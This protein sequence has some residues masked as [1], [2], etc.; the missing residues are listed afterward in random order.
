MR[1]HHVI[2][3]AAIALSATAASLAGLSAAPASAASARAVVTG[4][5]LHDGKPVKGAQITLYAWPAQSVLAKEAVGQEVPL[6][7]VGTA[8]S[9]GSGKFSVPA[10]PGSLAAV[11]DTANASGIVNLQVQAVYDGHGT[12]FYFPRRVVSTA[13]GMALARDVPGKPQLAAQT[14]SLKAP[15]ISGPAGEGCPPTLVRAKWNNIKTVIAGEYTHLD[16]VK[17]GFTYGTDSSS[18]LGGAEQPID[19]GW[20]ESG[21]WSVDGGTSQTWPTVH[22]AHGY[23][24]ISKFQYT[25]YT[26]A[27]T[28]LSTHVTNWDGSDITKH[29]KIPKATFCEEE[30][31]PTTVTLNTSKAWTFSQ[32]VSITKYIGIS[33]SAQSGYTKS[34]SES[35]TF[36]NRSKP[37]YLC[38]KKADPNVGEGDTPGFVVA[39]NNPRG[40]A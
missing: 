2:A 26:N 39:G 22:K 34:L 11:K 4:R 3:A 24:R 5:V 38:G 15:V 19:S 8:T 6:I 36:T 18:S 13:A 9:S 32:G 29:V 31:A 20:E 1:I 37:G 16:S 10:R 12:L 33:L 21:T 23:A 14:V 25:E 30:F 7:T 27:C 17:L 28:G 35:Y 40:G